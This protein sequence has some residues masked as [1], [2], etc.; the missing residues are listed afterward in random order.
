M[1]VIVVDDFGSMRKIVR[2]VLNELGFTDI[3]EAKH[4]K[5]AWE[6]II[7]NLD[8]P[9]KKIELGI[10]DWNMPVMTG[11]QLLQ[12]IRADEKT[13]DFLFV[14]LTAEKERDNIVAAVQSGVDEYM[15]KPFN[16]GTLQGKL[17]NIAKKKLA[18]VEKDIAE[19]F[20]AVGSDINTEDS[21]AGKKSNIAEFKRRIHKTGEIV[22]WSGVG[23]LALG[24]MFLRFKEFKQAEIVTRKA[25]ALDFGH[26][27][28][29]ALLSKILKATGKIPESAKA[30]RIA[31]TERP[32]SGELRQRLG[33]AYLH[34]GKYELAIQELEASLKLLDQKNIKLLARNSNILGKAKMEKGEKNNDDDLKNEAVG[35]MEN[36][37]KIDPDF[38]SA[39]YD[40]MVAYTKTG[41][42]KE[43][44]SIY[45][46]LQSAEPK[47]ADGWVSLGKAFLERSEP[48]KA[49][50]AF[51]K[52]DA[53]SDG[54]F[55]TYEEIATAL[56]R[57]DMLGEAVHYI[58]KSREINPSDISSYNLKGIV[59]RRRNLYSQA[60][61]EYVCASK[62]NPDD[63]GVFFNLGVAYFKSGHKG[64]SI[65]PFTK[66][67][68]L[69]PTLTE[70]DDYM[71]LMK[72]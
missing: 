9:D 43:A 45:K 13:S 8:I 3:T 56:I 12:K 30:L 64:K 48:K 66:A 63:A 11:L 35:D 1:R 47:D 60:V 6:K 4:G 68:E 69:D 67:K 65:I 61:K 46:S 2:N 41:R 15:V 49:M 18:A 57:N 55:A 27:E 23:N 58:D 29:H 34:E 72:S 25:I 24:K 39:H 71:K 38:I 36:A 54:R 7:E 32:K 70:A 17:Q 31:V 22:P 50:F 33:D 26:A 53:L 52:V 51:K 28:A 20:A 16:A 5:D 59:Y 42:T 19:Y 10:V 62:L 21:K 40:L 44:Q 14:M 37:V